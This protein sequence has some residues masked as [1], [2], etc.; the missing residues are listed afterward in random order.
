MTTAGQQGTLTDL[1]CKVKSELPPSAD[2]Q[3]DPDTDTIAR[4]AYEIYESRG[5][6]DGFALADWLQAERELSVS[7]TRRLAGVD[8]RSE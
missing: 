4:R 3:C 2:V 5:R 6:E 1:L 7:I 8:A